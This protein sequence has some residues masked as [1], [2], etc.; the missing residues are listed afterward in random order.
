MSLAMTTWANERHAPGPRA[1]AGAR[2]A[3]FV[4]PYT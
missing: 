2:Y 1:A 4:P 3:S